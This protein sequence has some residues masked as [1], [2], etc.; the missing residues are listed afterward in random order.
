M[1]IL[2]I[3]NTVYDIIDDYVNMLS[4]NI[5]LG[6]VK[7]LDMNMG[8]TIILPINAYYHGN[9]TTAISFN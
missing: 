6:S 8:S 1:V 7:Q 9:E 5:I 4:Y 2:R 3:A